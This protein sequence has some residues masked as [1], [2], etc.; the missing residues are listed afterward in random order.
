LRESGLLSNRLKTIPGLS[1]QQQIQMNENE[2]SNKVALF[3]KEGGQALIAQNDAAAVAR[4]TQEIQ[5]AL[6]IAQRFPRD[7]IRA[8]AKIIEA[9]GRKELADVS[10]YE[11]SRGGTKIVGPTIDLLRA[12]ANRWGNIRYGWTE[13]DRR[14]G[15]SSIRCFAWDV[16][17]NG[18]S[19][20]T[21]SVKHWRDT[22][23]GGYALKDERDIYELLANQAARRV[24][25]CLE[26]VI[27]ADMVIAAVDACRN[28]MKRGETI[29][30]KDRAVK[31]IVPF[32]EFGVTQGMIETFLGNKLDAVSENQLASLRRVYKALKD[33]VG[34]REDYFKG[35]VAKPD[36]TQ[37]AKTAGLK[38]HNAPADP[39]DN[40]PMGGPTPLA[41]PPDDG[42]GKPEPEQPAGGF[43]PLKYLRSLLVIAKVKEGVLLDYWAASGATDG[44]AASL[45]EVAMS[46][47]ELVKATGEGWVPFL[48]GMRKQMKK[49]E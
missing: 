13:V 22:S 11:Y 39:E 36:F 18:Q 12:I 23:S 9:C 10:E 2:Q 31:L 16:Q 6:T 21:F 19:E 28:T 14:D 32:G 25:A 35:E 34:R 44:S 5:A 27:D 1:N 29:P 46:N 45:E 26:E 47:P 49:G 40:V 17:T 15:Y 33:G 3:D 24:R 42:K 8:K 41:T 4:A 7:E 48:E 37:G 43:N 38:T 30:L 20:R